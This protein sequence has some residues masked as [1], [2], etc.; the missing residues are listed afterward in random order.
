[1]VLVNGKVYV[2]L[3][4][5]SAKF[6]TFI[7][8]R[9]VII[10]P[11]SDRVTGRIDL[12]GLKGCE[13]IYH[14]ARHEHPV[15]GLRRFVRRRRPEDRLGHRGDRP[16]GAHGDEGR[17]GDDV[18]PAR[19]L[20]V[21]RGDLALEGLHDDDGHLRR[22][23]EQIEGSNDKAFTFDPASDEPTALGLEASALDLGRGAVS[24]GKLYVPDAT[25]DKPRV[26]VFD[27]SGTGA[28]TELESFD[29]DPAKKLPPREI[30]WY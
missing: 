27:A 1:M 17:A 8:G 5:S 15:R 23:E 13:A 3:Y 11:T 2:T 14:A 7:S 10:D 12:P 4:E 22:P 16:L 21:G 30:A 6:D 19:E 24:G 26:H 20:P 9:V 28:P 25:F 18:R 29:P